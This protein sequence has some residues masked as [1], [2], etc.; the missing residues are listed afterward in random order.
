[1]RDF[2]V[3]SARGR[4]QHQCESVAQV[5]VE[6]VWEPG[7]ESLFCHGISGLLLLKM[8]GSGEWQL[9]PQ[10][11]LWLMAQPGHE[12]FANLMVMAH[13]RGSLGAVVRLRP[14]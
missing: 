4:M 1:M 6:F 12:G 7:A 13:T 5:P 9:N 2:N 11:S 10:E 3:M 8:P 14:V